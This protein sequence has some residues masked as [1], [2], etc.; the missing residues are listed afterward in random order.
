MLEKDGKDQKFAGLT[1]DILTDHAIE[2]LEQRPSSK[3][4][5]LVVH[6]RAPHAPWLPVAPEDWEPF[7]NLDVQP[8]HPDYPGLDVKRVKK[9]T[10]EYLA[11]VRGVDRN[12][13]SRLCDSAADRD[14]LLK[15]QSRC[16]FEPDVH[17]SAWEQDGILPF[18]TERPS[19]FWRGTLSTT[20]QLNCSFSL[21]LTGFLIHSIRAALQKRGCIGRI[22]SLAVGHKI[23]I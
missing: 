12:V 22:L 23:V 20:G 3:P 11:S 5:L 8:P 17:D 7:D 14:S 19:G 6:Y 16:H 1:T 9:V 15:D 10:R 2:F 4:F 18:F 13:G 21:P